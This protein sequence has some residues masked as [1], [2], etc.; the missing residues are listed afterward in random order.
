MASVQQFSAKKGTARIHIRY[1]GKQ[2]AGTVKVDNER[3]AQR[4]AAAAET[5]VYDL[6]RGMITIPHNIDVKAFILTGGQVR[7]PVATPKAEQSNADRIVVPTIGSIFDT[8]TGTLTSGSKEANSIATERI[9]G[10]HICR[11]LGTDCRFDALGVD[12]LQRY[13]D[14]R[15][16]E[17]VVRATIKK[18]LATLRVVWHWAHKRKHIATPLAWKMSDLTF[19]KA[20]EKPPFQTWDQ[21]TRRIER[22]GLTEQ[23]AELWECLFLDTNQ[24]I[25]CLAWVKE[26]APHT[27]VHPMFVFAA[28]TGVRRGEIL[29]S[30]RD[31][32]DF[33]RSEVAIR[34]KKADRS[35]HFSMRRVWVNPFLAGVMREWFERNAGSKYAICSDTGKPVNERTATKYFR[36][37]LA[38]SKWHILHG[39]HVF[40]HSL[41]SSMA[42]AGVDQQTISGLLGHHTEE[43]ERRYRRLFPRKQEQARRSLFGTATPA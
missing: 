38:T 27:F 26:H 6:Q 42:A 25:E 41:A 31:D 2:F 20:H 5:T 19:S 8:Y 7:K 34:Q 12:T 15:D 18:E 43:M 24:T 17:G 9:H 11:V 13:V 35:K 40:R 29:H 21:I 22:G 3:H 28:H 30:E 1:Q 4:L 36:K 23:Q 14:K 33:D 32:W 37:A 16:R 10:R 39:F